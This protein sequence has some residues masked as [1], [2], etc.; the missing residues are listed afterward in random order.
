MAALQH[1][2]AELVETFLTQ[3]DRRTHSGLKFSDCFS[4]K[5]FELVFD[6]G[7]T[8]NTSAVRRA[9]MA[10]NALPPV[11]V[12]SATPVRH[13][14]FEKHLDNLLR[15]ILR[16][17]ADDDTV[18]SSDRVIAKLLIRRTGVRTPKTSSKETG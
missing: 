17:I 8:L 5:A 12:Q 14:T 2:D 1:A 11:D 9:L 16:V 15:H 7:T 6:H 13:I 3:P 10:C 18:G 4:L